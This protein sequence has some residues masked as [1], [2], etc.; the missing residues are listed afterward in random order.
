[1]SA[2]HE[3]GYSMGPG[4]RE[5]M[6]TKNVHK[7]EATSR[8]QFEELMKAMKTMQEDTLRENKLKEEL[9]NLKGPKKNLSWKKE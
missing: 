6:N 3:G 4:L 1:M 8:E 9:R 5:Q 2:I 7:F